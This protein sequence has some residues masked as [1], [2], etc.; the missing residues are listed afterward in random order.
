MIEYNI[1]YPDVK[2]NMIDRDQLKKETKILQC[3]HCS[4]EYVIQR[5]KEIHLRDD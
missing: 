4:Y 5:T 3:P 1:D 2:R